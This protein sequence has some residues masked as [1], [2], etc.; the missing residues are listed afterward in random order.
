MDQLPKEEQKE[1]I[2]QVLKETLKD[3]VDE[4]WAMFGKW[5]FRGLL[6]LVFAFLVYVWGISHGFKVTP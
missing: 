4:Q 1:L 3:F 6:A 5:S 2:R